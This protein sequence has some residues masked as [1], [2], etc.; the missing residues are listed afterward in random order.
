[1]PIYT[2]DPGFDHLTNYIKKQ[3][4]MQ[5]PFPAGNICQYFSSSPLRA[6]KYGVLLNVAK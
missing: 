3:A 4:L 5:P 6:L 1:M 2:T